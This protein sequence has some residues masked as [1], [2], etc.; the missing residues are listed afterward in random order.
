[1]AF[2]ATPTPEPGTLALFGLGTSFFLLGKA[3]R[4]KTRQDAPGSK[5]CAQGIK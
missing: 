5:D 3:R 2:V 1:V 4:K